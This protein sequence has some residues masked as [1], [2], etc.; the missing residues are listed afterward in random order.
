[1]AT[2]IHKGNPVALEGSMP[3]VGQKAP[4]FKVVKDDL[5]EVSLDSFAGKVKV[6]VGVPSLDTPVCQKE[7]REFN[8]KLAGMK[9]TVVLVISG[10][11]PFAMKRFCST[12]GIQNVVTGSQFRDMSFSKNYGVHIA[13][14]GLK[15]LSARAV[16]VVDKNNTVQYAELV[17]EIGLEPQY[18]KT[19]EAVQKLI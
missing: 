15:G 1:M 12:E 6:L 4:D 17:P 16:F 5:S 19:I 8:Q 3:G 14:G 13:E 9:D 10:D 7:T 11:L 18:D 2:V